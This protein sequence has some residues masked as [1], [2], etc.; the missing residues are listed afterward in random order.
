MKIFTY[1]GEKVNISTL[2]AFPGTY[3]IECWGGQGLSYGGKGGYV[4]GFIT[5]RS[6]LNLYIYVG[7]FGVTGK[8]G[9]A[10][11]GGGRSQN[12]GGGASDVRLIYSESWDDFN[13]LKS[14]IIVA[15]GGG[16]ADKYFITEIGADPGGAGGGLIGNN[17]YYNCGK[18]ANQTSGGEGNGPGK[19]GKG[20]SNDRFDSS[21]SN[22]GNGGG[23]G[24]YFGGGASVNES[25][26][27]GG[28]GSSFISGHP[29]CIAIDNSSK[30]EDNIIMKDDNVHYSGYKF[31]HTEM[32]NGESLMPSI[33]GGFETGHSGYGAVRIT[34][35]TSYL[36]TK[37]ISFLFHKLIFLTII[38]ILKE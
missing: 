8:A 28:G 15:S 7:G 32:Y 1:L 38:L 19:F 3:K 20:G 4:S 35:F 13:S 29:G 26:S 36:M 34:Y 24:G 12:G 27:G 22:D 25:K 9:S 23:G 31:I 10:F 30:D 33:N 37:Q 17:S 21:G 18:G 14:R 16:S 6:I 11:N 2:K 5:F